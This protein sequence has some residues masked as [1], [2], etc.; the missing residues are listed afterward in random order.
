MLKTGWHLSDTQI[1]QRYAEVAQERRYDLRRAHNLIVRAIG[2][3]LKAKWLPDG[4][5]NVLDIGC[6]TGVLLE[7]LAKSFPAWRLLGIDPLYSDLSPRNPTNNSEIRHGSAY[8]VPAPTNSQDLIILSE[9]LEHLNRPHQALREVSR[10]LKPNSIALLTVPNANAFIGWRYFEKYL[11]ARRARRFLPAEHPARTWQPI[12]TLYEYEELLALVRENNFEI[13]ATD[14]AEF[15]PPFLHSAPL[16]GRYIYRTCNL[17]RFAK[18]LFPERFGYR[19]LFALRTT[20][21][22]RTERDSS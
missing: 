11:P 21:L 1:A 4:Q 9:V 5:I 7:R 22:Q 6:G 14:S 2:T 19:L 15:V 8:E 16:F 13:L 17:D 20:G 10:L 12:D 3:C 18:V